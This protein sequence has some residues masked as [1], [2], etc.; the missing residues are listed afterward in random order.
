MVSHT[1][2]V[3]GF[4]GTPKAKSAITIDGDLTETDW[5]R[6]RVLHLDGPRQFYKSEKPG[7]W[8]GPDDL[9]GTLRFLWDEKY[10]YLSV[11]V[12]DN[13]FCNPSQDGRLWS[14]DGLQF[15]IDP[16]RDQRATHGR[17]DIAMG[18]GRK[19]PQAWCHMSADV[20]SPEGELPPRIAVAPAGPRWRRVTIGDTCERCVDTLK[21]ALSRKSSRFK[22]SA[23]SPAWALGH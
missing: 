23:K 10:L 11:D 8:N 4:V 22:L 18:I 5:Q 1:R 17:Y 14:M 15:L 12:V 7:H 6:A 13:V 20:R 9:T 21:I 2:L 16:A 3:G 19:G